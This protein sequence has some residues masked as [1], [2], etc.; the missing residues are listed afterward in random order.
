METLKRDWDSKLT[1]RDVLVTISCLLIQPNPDSALNAEAGALIQ[2]DYDAFSRRAK[3]MTSIHANIPKALQV[4]VQE[5]QERGQEQS[6]AGEESMMDRDAADPDPPM[7]RRRITARERGTIAS[8]RSEGSPSGG[9]GRRRQQ[10]APSQPF[11]VQTGN[12]DVFGSL[13]PPQPQITLVEDEDDSSMID[14]NQENDESKS[15][16]KASTPK[17][18]TP[19]RPQGIAIPLGELTMDEELSESNEDDD[20]EPEYPPSPRKSPAK[21]KLPQMNGVFAESSRDATR[22]APNITPPSNFFAN[23]LAENS[24][25]VT[26]HVVSAEP[27]SASPRKARAR[28]QTPSSSRPPLFPSIFTPRNN[29]AN[30]GVFKPKSP[31]ASE[32]KRAAAKRKFEMDAKLWEL[33]GRDIQRWNRGDF[34]TQPFEMKAKR[35]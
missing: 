23:P 7:K 35:W 12:D 18:A 15:P 19:R 24:P 22:R 21:Q 34:D 3:L 27:F 10:P 4:A 11:V 32:K 25:F 33:C 9:V 13:R 2:E 28:P 29:A 30:T 16:T 5:A 26:A 8:R 14:V 31:S 1:L 17:I 6:T 20:M